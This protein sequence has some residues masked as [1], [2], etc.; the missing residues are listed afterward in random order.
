M[1]PSHLS[2]RVILYSSS[3]GLQFPTSGGYIQDFCT[4]T[5][6]FNNTCNHLFRDVLIGSEEASSIGQVHA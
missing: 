2:I 1:G 6:T 3:Q 5:M 4:V